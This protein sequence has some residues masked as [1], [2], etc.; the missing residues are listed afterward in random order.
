MKKGS[1]P[2]DG[3]NNVTFLEGNLA[4]FIKFLQNINFF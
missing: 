3:M 1:E 2:A 4:N